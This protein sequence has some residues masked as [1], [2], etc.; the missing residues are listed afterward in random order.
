MRDR[1]APVSLHVGSNQPEIGYDKLAATI[2]R[3]RAKRYARILAREIDTDQS[4]YDYHNRGSG[5]R[6]AILEN[7]HEVRRIRAVDGVNQWWPLH[8]LSEI[9]VLEP[10][11]PPSQ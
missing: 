3:F 8:L 5:V 11:A 1:A 4:R 6:D 9:I 2:E 10:N 7:Y